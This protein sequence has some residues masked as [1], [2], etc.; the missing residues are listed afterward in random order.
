M[1]PGC[2]TGITYYITPKMDRLLDPQ[3]GHANG[4]LKIPSERV[5]CL[6][7]GNSDSL[8][9]HFREHK[10]FILSAQRHRWISKPE[11]LLALP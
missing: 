2:L 8:K 7:S 1:L 10:A 5:N 6:I 3:V 4:A 11:I 9:Q